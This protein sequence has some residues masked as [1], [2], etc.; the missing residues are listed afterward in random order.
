MEKGVPVHFPAVLQE[1]SWLAQTL[2]T[3]WRPSPRFYMP[4]PG[5]TAGVA[6]QPLSWR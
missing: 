2:S 6:W 5:L 1:A 3:I 4:L